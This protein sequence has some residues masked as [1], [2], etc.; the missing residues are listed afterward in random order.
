MIK[1]QRARTFGWKFCR[2][3]FLKCREM[4]L[5]RMRSWACEACYSLGPWDFPCL[6]FVLSFFFSFLHKSKDSNIQMGYMTPTKT[7]GCDKIWNCIEATGPLDSQ[8]IITFMGLSHWHIS[9]DQPLAKSP[10]YIS[11]TRLEICLQYKFDDA[12]G[13]DCIPWYLHTPKSVTISYF[14]KQGVYKSN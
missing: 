3:K 6:D 2:I 12:V 14:V 10:N 13:P 1:I 9:Q 7:G 8:L 4:G 5:N 11:I